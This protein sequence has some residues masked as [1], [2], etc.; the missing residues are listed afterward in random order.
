MSPCSACRTQCCMSSILVRESSIAKVYRRISTEIR[1]RERTSLLPA[2][3]LTVYSEYS[4]HHGSNG[5]NGD[6]ENRA[7]PAVGDEEFLKVSSAYGESVN[8]KFHDTPSGV[9]AA[10]FVPG[11]SSPTVS[12]T[13]LPTADYVDT[14]DKESYLP[15]GEFVVRAVD[16]VCLKAN[17]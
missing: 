17:R 3:M 16:Q 5:G 10:F 9:R 12:K 8:I 13:L 6:K 2:G 1:H 11:S 7:S 4:R 15:V 14:D